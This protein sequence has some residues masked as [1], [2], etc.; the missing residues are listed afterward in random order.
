MNI[1]RYYSGS[2]TAPSR[3]SNY[4]SHLRLLSCF[5]VTQFFVKLSEDF[6]FGHVASS[7]VHDVFQ[8]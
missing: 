5:K 3:N 6:T 7:F 8:S 1:R 2:H 4:M